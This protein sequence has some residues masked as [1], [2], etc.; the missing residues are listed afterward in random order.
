MKPQLVADIGGTWLLVADKIE[1]SF[2]G[3]TE[4]LS[5][6]ESDKSWTGNGARGANQAAA[7][8]K[9]QSDDLTA[10]LRAMAS[11]LNYVSGWL[12]QTKLYMPHS[13]PT[14]ADYDR[15][16][17]EDAIVKRARLGFVSWYVPG[18]SAAGPAVPMLADP[19]APMPG[20]GGPTNYYTGGGG[21]GQTRGKVGPSGATPTFGDGSKSTGT[22]PI[23]DKGTNPDGSNPNGDKQ[24]GANPDGSNP[25]GSNP[26]GNPNGSNPTGSNPGGTD[27]TSGQSG[28]NGSQLSQLVAPCNR[29][30]RICRGRPRR[31]SSRTW[32]S[33]WR[34]HRCP[35]C[36]TCS[37]T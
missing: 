23:T 31:T 24:N 27:Q 30:C 28:Q 6:M 34:I 3:L 7:R 15:P 2:H 12:D 19:T 5:K 9:T 18:L 33:S 36:R 21:G 37:T 22:K 11:N 1:K 14:D 16:Q 17:R 13:A 29:A 20:S 8:F 26:G 25:N 35:H 10:D 4:R 32:P